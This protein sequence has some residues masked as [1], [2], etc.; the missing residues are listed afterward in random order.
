[1]TIDKS[2]QIK[3]I[4]YML[5]YAFQELRK[6]NYDN[7][8]SE[9]FEKIHDL[10]AEILYHAI[11]YQ[12]KQGLYK[13][14][15]NKCDSLNTLKGRLNIKETIFLKIA[16][17]TQIACEFDELSENNIYNQIIKT[18]I[19]ILLRQSDIE[20]LRKNALKKLLLY[21]HSIDNVDLY[22]ISWSR[23]Q[24]DRNNRN[25]QMILYICYFVINSLLL[26]TEKGKYKLSSFS[27]EN[28]SRLFEKFI[29][30][31]FRYH[32]PD[33]SPRSQQINWDIN[34][35]ESSMNLLP[36]M[37]TDTTLT[38]G[39]KTLIIDAKY[40]QETLIYNYD[41]PKLR[42]A[43]LYQIYSY[44]N[45]FDKTHSGKVDGIVLYAKTNDAICPDDIIVFNSGNTIYFK[46]I[47]LNQDF[48]C[49]KNQLDSIVALIK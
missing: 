18:T 47:D 19:Q 36:L 25:Y 15:I 1:M 24:F 49:I 10:F 21:F 12:L 7:I 42:S 17:R 8:E 40:Y 20:P 4:Y 30:E 33:T 13:E 34:T 5:S 6:N 22:N 38:W 14:Y 44:V 45:S 23:L 27:D 41:K 3:N 2:I 32:H 35:S 9:K 26:S 28:M 48:N 39:G 31:Y 11:S 29:L 46:T 43:H 37:K 16:H